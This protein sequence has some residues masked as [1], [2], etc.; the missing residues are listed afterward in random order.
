MQRSTERILTTHTGSLPRPERL[1]RLFV[2]RAGGEAIDPAEIAAAGREALRAIVPKQA[3][4]GIDV[5]NNGEQQRESFF[6]YLRERLTGL[7]GSWQRPSRAGTRTPR[8]R[9]ERCRV[10]FLDQTSESA[11]EK[12]CARTRW[13]AR[14]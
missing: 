1:K 14:A 8:R 6:L 2:A 13:V 9:D 10:G 5:G 11:R 4:A 3:Q 7:G 12:L